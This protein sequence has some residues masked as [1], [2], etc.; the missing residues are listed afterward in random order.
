MTAQ[1]TPDAL[2]RPGWQLFNRLDSWLLA[3]AP[4]ERLA[5]FRILV[6][7]YA[8]IA[9]I[10][11]VGE[12][13]RLADRPAVQF[14]PVGIANLLE[15]PLPSTALWGLFGLSVLSG[16]AF[17]FGAGFRY[18]GWVF[19]ACQLTW[20]TYHASWGQMLHFEHL[21]TLH[22]LV[23]GFAPAAHAYSVDAFRRQGSVEPDTRYGWPLRL[24]AIITVVT[25]A[26]AGIA[27][28]RIGGVEW[29]NS[30]TL[31]NHIAYS[32]TR[33][34]LLG[35]PRPPLASLAIANDWVLQPM[36][37]A[38][39]AVELFAPLA[40]LGGWFRR[41]WVPSAILLHLGTLT[42]MFVFFS[43]NGLGFALLPLYRLERLVPERVR[44]HFASS[45]APR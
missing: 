42:L 27:K 45:D 26:L 35:E 33:M 2:R 4:A 20:A 28:L 31:T 11:S 14:E 7:S 39:V 3:P 6:G 24:A 10:V 34:D 23:L 30:E 15:G 38:S 8:T 43:Y 29:L 1:L 36:A 37:I 18:T 19:A 16:F 5:V 21:V 17:T 32:A 25:Y 44:A 12:F 41:A 22:V 13:A 40:L 9:M